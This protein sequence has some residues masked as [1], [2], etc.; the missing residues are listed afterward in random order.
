MKKLAVL[1]GTLILAGC[2]GGNDVECD[3]DVTKQRIIEDF[4]GHLTKTLPEGAM[5]YVSSI[6]LSEIVTLAADK[7][8]KTRSC[9]GKVIIHT[10]SSDATA[11]Q[12][13]KYTNQSVSGG[14]QN[15]RTIYEYID[16]FRY[17][18]GYV[19]DIVKHPYQNDI[20]KKAGFDSYSKYKIY[21][22]AK[23]RLVESK[24]E[25]AGLRESI[26]EIE[27]KIESMRPL[28]EPVEEAIRGGKSVLL[29]NRYISMVP[30]IVKVGDGEEV[31]FTR[32]L[33]FNSEVKNTSS[34][35]FD[36]LYLD[37]DI[38]IDGQNSPFQ[39]R[40]FVSVSPDEGFK[41]GESRKVKVLV[42]G[43]TGVGKDF[44]STTAWK[45]AKSV[46][47]ILSPSRYKDSQGRE[48]HM[49][50]Y[51]NAFSFRNQKK[52][53]PII[54]YQYRKLFDAKQVKIERKDKL[55]NQIAR[56]ESVV[57]ARTASMPAI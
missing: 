38:Y 23:Q 18:T 35:T 10:S 55:E 40:Q 13:V 43:S 30:V 57:G 20:A 15:T 45:E 14:E 22:D 36:S 25:L 1:S 24:R 34:I 29:T 17:I 27:S 8:A 48:G 39:T 4:K 41:P 31:G 54:W 49:G 6:E 2:F 26:S 12:G 33:A 32:S 44:F 7:E 50:E 46:Q 28:I 53:E 56:D 47:I 51:S 11:Y 52:G 19:F 9:E 3:S 5:K 21:E 16:T 42:S 37:A